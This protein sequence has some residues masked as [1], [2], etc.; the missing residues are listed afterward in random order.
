M[1]PTRQK[2]PSAVRS[3]EGTEAYPT[4]SSLGEHAGEESDVEEVLRLHDP[5][6]SPKNGNKPP[7]ATP[8][9]PNSMPVCLY[10]QNDATKESIHDLFSATG[11][12]DVPYYVKTYQS[13]QSEVSHVLN[14]YLQVAGPT[15]MWRPQLIDG[16]PDT[17]KRSFF[18]L[19]MKEPVMFEAVVAISQ[20]HLDLSQH[21][22]SR[23][24]TAVLLHHGKVLRMLQDSL[25][26]SPGPKVQDTALMA[27][28]CMLVLDIMYADWTSVKANMQGFRHLASLRGGMD[29]LGWSGWFRTC[30]SWAEL[31]WAGHVARASSLKKS[32][33]PLKLPTYPAHPFNP[34]TCLSISRLP[35]GLREAALQRKL[36]NEV[37]AFLEQVQIWMT[38]PQKPC[39]EFWTRQP[40]ASFVRDRND[41]L[42]SLRISMQGTDILG[43]YALKPSER[44][45]C[46]GVIAYII[47]IDSSVDDGRQPRGLDDHMAG[48]QAACSEVALC[49]Y[50]LWAGLVLAA[51]RD[52]AMAPLSNHCVLLDRMLELDTRNDYRHWKDVKPLLRKYFWNPFIEAKW[53][54]CWQTA[55][56]RKFNSR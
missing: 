11:N 33:V 3:P 41:Y 50:L 7:H 24:S 10:S 30:F 56:S 8:P 38:G 17:F 6:K 52:S 43:T 19:S 55:I 27:V 51:S 53:E 26:S 37:I 9:D 48:M 54:M 18:Q 44:L 1:K 29:N 34:T 28:F 46:I 40:L 12:L 21:P 23:P 20:A 49:E 22:G 35:E 13:S 14:Y 39:A 36:S 5:S 15:A 25:V 2:K 32:S 45:L 31:R 47:S 42:K 4:P 16:D